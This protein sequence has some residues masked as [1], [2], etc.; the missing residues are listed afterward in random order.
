MDF[1]FYNIHNDTIISNPRSFRTSLVVHTVKRLPTMQEIQIRS[2][3]QED[4]LEKEM[5]THSSTL[6]RKIPWTE[7]PGMLQSIGSQRVGHSDSTF[8]FPA[9]NG[10]PSQSQVIKS[11]L[12]SPRSS[13][14]AQW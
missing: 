10:L 3:G 4:P 2:L 8:T 1:F 5:A 12:A 6:A 9:A 7:E 13:Q 14:V 11:L